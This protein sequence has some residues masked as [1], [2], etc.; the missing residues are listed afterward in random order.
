MPNTWIAVAALV[1]DSDLQVRR[2]AAQ[3]VG[4]FR[5]ASARTALEQI[6]ASDADAAARRNAAWALG[7][8]GDQASRPV[9]EAATEDASSLVR[10]TARAS[11]RQL[12]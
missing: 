3:V 4:R 5:V 12:R 2:A 10:L 8:I 6:V 11:I 7:R 9:L 1:S